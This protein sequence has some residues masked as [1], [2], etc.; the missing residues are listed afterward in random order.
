MIRRRIPSRSILDRAYRSLVH[1]L[2]YIGSRERDT[3]GILETARR[4][5]F[6]EKFGFTKYPMYGHHCNKCYLYSGRHEI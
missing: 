1:A 3:W 4:E 6:R 5:L 2:Y